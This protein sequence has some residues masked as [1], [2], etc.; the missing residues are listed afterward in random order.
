MVDKGI[1][2]LALKSLT[3]FWKPPSVSSTYLHINPHIS[4]TSGPR[5]NGSDQGACRIDAALAKV[6]QSF[7]DLAALP[8]P[9]RR[10]HRYFNHRRAARLPHDPFGCDPPQGP[11]TRSGANLARTTAV[12]WRKRHRRR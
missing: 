4:K 3:R 7:H 1:R 2:A 5:N 11:T 9:D 10:S 6:P 8:Y 12:L